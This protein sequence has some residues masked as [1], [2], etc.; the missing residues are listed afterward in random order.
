MSEN[1]TRTGIQRS[2]AGRVV[3]DK[4][5][6]SITVLVERQVQ[7]P[8]YKKYIKRSTKYRV[9]DEHNACHNG[10]W[11]QITECRPLSKT[12]SWTL[13]RIVESATRSG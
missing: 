2:L 1:N 5:D 6:K 9:H 11:V 10:D 8:L 7:H 13:L 4:M 12:K 3:S